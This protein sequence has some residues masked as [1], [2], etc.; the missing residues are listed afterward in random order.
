MIAYSPNTLPVRYARGLLST[1]SPS[2]IKISCFK[3]LNQKIYWKLKED[4]TTQNENV[5]NREI[6][7]I[8]LGEPET[9]MS[10]V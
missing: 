1:I 7:Y 3:S 10:N 2:L 9:K 6:D 8:V 4:L 5:G